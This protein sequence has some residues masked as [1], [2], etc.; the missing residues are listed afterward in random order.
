[1]HSLMLTRTTGI[2]GLISSKWPKE[3]NHHDQW[4]S[5]GLDVVNRLVGGDGSASHHPAPDGG[6]TESVMFPQFRGLRALGDGLWKIWAEPWPS[7]LDDHAECRSAAMCRTTLRNPQ[8]THRT[9]L[10]SLYRSTSNS[11][12]IYGRGGL[13]DQLADGV[14]Q[15]NGGLFTSFLLVVHNEVPSFEVRAKRNDT[16]WVGYRPAA[17][18]Q[19]SLST[20]GENDDHYF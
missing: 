11:S 8:L 7:M 12:Y 3:P 10:L 19:L 14:R 4:F 17:N 5:T 9:I 16:H 20:P 15:S 2:R 1:M 6:D 13:G 18:F